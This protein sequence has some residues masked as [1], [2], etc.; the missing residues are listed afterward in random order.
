M[1]GLTERGGVPVVHLPT[2]LLS[3]YTNASFEPVRDL[4]TS[5]HSFPEQPHQDPPLTP[6]SP[7]PL[8]LRAGSL[9]PACCR[10]PSPV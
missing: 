10:D 4:G 3:V 1:S 8:Q 5:G 9:V 7:A 6:S 2:L